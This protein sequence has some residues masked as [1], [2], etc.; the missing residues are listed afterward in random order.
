MEL[1]KLT[2][3]ENYKIEIALINLTILFYLTRTSLPVFKYPFLILYVFLLIK[4]LII[5]NKRIVPALVE[6]LRNYFLLLILGL[7]LGASFLLSDKLYL[8]VFKDIINTIILLSLFLM[9]TIIVTSIKEF[10]FYVSNLIYLIVLF[11]FIIS[12]VGLLFFFDILTHKDFYYNNYIT[13]LPESDSSKVDYNFALLPVFF[14]FLSVLILTTKIKNN[15]IKI[16]LNLLLVVLSLQILFSGSRRGIIVFTLV[17]IFLTVSPFIS[18]IFKSSILKEITKISVPFLILMFALAFSTYIFIDWAPCSFKNR[19]LESI[20]SKNILITKTKI[21]YKIL[22]YVSILN[23]SANYNDLY[24]LLWTPDFDPADPD[25]GWGTRIHK[26]IFPLKGEGVEIVPKNAMGYLMDSTCN[27]SYY[28]ELNLCESY[29]SVAKIAVCKGFRYKASVFCFVSDNFNINTTSIE[30]ESS[31]INNKIVTG[32]VSNSYDYKNKGKW[33]KLELEFEGNENYGEVNIYMSFRANEIKDFKKLK[34]YIIFAYPYYEKIF[35]S[36]SI[37]TPNLTQSKNDFTESVRITLENHKGE[38]K[39]NKALNIFGERYENYYSNFSSSNF[40][41]RN[42]LFPLLTF[43]SN[44]R[45][46]ITSEIFSF[47][48][49]ILH[50]SDIDKVDKDPLRNLVS[51]FISEDTTYYPFKE[52]VALDMVPGTYM[53]DRISRWEFALRIYLKEYNLKQRFIG[54]GFNFL[55]WY[56][57][58]FLNDKT[59]PDWPH[60]PFLSILLYSGIIGL[61][62]YMFFIYK[63]FYYYLKYK[64]EY[65]LLFIFFLITFFFSFFSGGSPFDPPVMGFFAILP[66]FINSVMKNDKGLL[67][68][69]IE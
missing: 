16:L 8:T 31:S 36:D 55:N 54:G 19:F 38:K 11:A 40:V 9:L 22:R 28:P 51:K 66:F 59:K 14:G 4:F 43:P 7:I 47:P 1:K 62:I 68:K 41:T 64:K 3:S 23:A 5:Y 49:S 18:R 53:E 46:N 58:Y 2:A 25:S 34:G 6:F 24:N 20:G 52:I 50:M 57:Y 67:N 15:F 56:G 39:I 69:T 30:V 33:Q 60:N 61:S 21:T 27:A 44:I 29:S 63:V 13:V 37:L 10:K 65:P 42:S 17:I 26:T 45:Q 35:N 12:V 32:K 48:L